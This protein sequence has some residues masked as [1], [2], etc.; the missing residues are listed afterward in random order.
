MAAM[1][2]VVEFHVKR[3]DA[4]RIAGHRL[5]ALVG[6]KIISALHERQCWIRFMIA[7][8]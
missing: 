4:R 1:A 8:P 6:K 3:L 7:T 2:L 5:P